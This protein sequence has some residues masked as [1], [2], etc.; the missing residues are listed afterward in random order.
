MKLNNETRFPY[1]V[2]DAQNGDYK[3]GSFS[4]TLRIIEEPSSGK[5]QVN[6]VVIVDEKELLNEITCGNAIVGLFFTC[7]DTYF[8]QFV[9]LE[10]MDGAKDFRAGLLRGRTIIKPLIISQRKIQEYVNGN[11]HEEYG[12]EKINFEVGSLLA[13]GDELIINVGREKLAPMETIFTLAVNDE[14]NEGEIKVE[15]ETESIT[16]YS[17]NKTYQTI[18]NLRATTLG[19]SILLN[20][21]YL[22]IVMEVLSHLNQDAASFADKKW[23][24]VF[25]AKCEHLG[26]D[27]GKSNFLEDAQKLLK[28]PITKLNSIVEDF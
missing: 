4:V 6:Y 27:Y 28:S 26:I 12:N 10:N 9:P 16:I 2:L 25:N 1:P 18:N 24:R 21:I 23:F 7:L 8:N 5:M 22:P 15:T 14:M 20:S 17:S 13:I 3:Q 19:K 11:L